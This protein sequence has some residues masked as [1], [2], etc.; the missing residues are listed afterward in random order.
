MAA[1][2]LNHKSLTLRVRAGLT[3]G[4][5]ES[6]EALAVMAAEQQSAA[7]AARLFA[8]TSAA[9][10]SL[11]LPRS[12]VSM[13]EVRRALALARTLIGDGAYIA[14]EN[15]GSALTLDAATS[16]ATRGRGDR[17]RPS[18][19]WASLTPTELQV[20]KL[21]AEGLSN[22][23]IASR[24]FIARGTVKTHLLHVFAKLGLTS[25]AGLAAEATRHG[26]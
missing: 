25:R 9:R 5:L 24:L 15:E 23:E 16:Y 7:E 20:V 8:A 19:G 4:V 17:K 10:A 18:A 1:E 21:A 2:S 26:A 12:P 6:L 11:G 22:P 14:A 3:P 13:T